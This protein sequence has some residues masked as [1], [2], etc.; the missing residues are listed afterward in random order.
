[1]IFTVARSRLFAVL[2]LG[3]TMPSVAALQD[4]S[5]PASQPAAG[6]SR[7]AGTVVNAVS[8]SPLARTRV[9]L[10]DAR[11]PQNVR[12]TITSDDG[13]FEFREIAAGKYELR[14]A[15]R[16]FIA[17]S[18]EQHEQFSTAIVTGVG[19]DT[20]H[21]LLRLA[22]FALLSG[23]VLNERGEPVREALV[24]LYLEDRSAGLERI[25][26]IRQERT[27]DQGSY[28][29]WP[30][31]A[32]TYFLAA[33]A[34]PWYALHPS[35]FDRPEAATTPSAFDP[36]LDVAYPPTYYKDATE[37]DQASP[38]PIRG[39]DHL[40][41]DVHLNPVPALHL[42]F[43]VPDAEQNGWT[44]PTLLKPSFDGMEDVPVDNAGMVSR[45]LFEITGVAAGRYTVQMPVSRPGEPSETSTVEMDLNTDGEELDPSKGAPASSV[46]AAVGLA[47]QEKLPPHVFIL[48]RNS[49]LR[50]VA[51]QQVDDKGEIEFRNLSPGNYELLAE[52]PGKAYSVFRISSQG[53]EISGDVLPLSAGSSVSIAITL[54]GSALRVEG[55]ATRNGQPVSGAMVVLVPKNPGSSRDLFRR[56]QSDLDGSFSLRNVIPG[57]YTVCAI[58][59]GWDLDWA[60]PA[61]ITSYCEH[62]RQLT[63]PHSAA[64]SM[65][66]ESSVEVQSR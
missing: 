14:G 35:S 3:L 33:T 32:G 8:G 51:S 18:Y 25:Q 13:R 10:R 58:E 65:A 53:T 37:P 16:G 56:D 6:V 17:A 1:M 44:M 5:S 36:S 40:E 46:H 50:V 23:K 45:G 59:N 7:I 57:F 27:D 41:A 60:K 11:N 19:L 31:N 30:L 4:S 47:G 48:L 22:P 28:E 29:F 62:G 61:V 43:Q 9:S 63:I 38:I 34:K 20:E 24:S 52:A 39:G 64:G 26:R 54:M 55:F 21:L 42:R 15:K 12:W 49:K 2:V 66:L